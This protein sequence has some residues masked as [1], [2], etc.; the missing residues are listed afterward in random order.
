LLIGVGCGRNTDVVRQ[1][2]FDAINADDISKV[3]QI[4]PP[5]GTTDLDPAT[6]KA[7]LQLA[8]DRCAEA[9]GSP[10][11]ARRFLVIE[12]LSRRYR[13]L[14]GKPVNVVGT[15]SAGLVDQGGGTFTAGLL[16]LRTSGSESYQVAIS[17]DETEY[18]ENASLD[19]QVFLV[20]F[21]ATY[22]INGV[23]VGNVIQA[24]RVESS[25]KPT[26]NGMVIPVSLVL[27]S[28][29]DIVVPRIEAY[30]ARQKLTEKATGGTSTH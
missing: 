19:G 26:G 1:K 21:D 29:E 27:P 12:F 17:K 3:R 10:A 22:K 2:L 5:D 6:Y 11:A 16:T 7:A 9:N 23:L 14:V 13:H 15:L 8:A 28:T 4:V 25:R 24:E 30:Q 20:N 18:T